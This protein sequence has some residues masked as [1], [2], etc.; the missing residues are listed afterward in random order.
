MPF[1]RSSWSLRISSMPY[2]K[3]RPTFA[4][5][6]TF[7]AHRFM[8][9]YRASNPIIS[10]SCTLVS[11][12]VSPGDSRQSR[13]AAA[14][15]EYCSS[16]RKMGRHGTRLLA[17]RFY[18]QP[19]LR[20]SLCGLAAVQSGAD[21]FAL[22]AFQLFTLPLEFT[23]NALFA[24]PLFAERKRTC[25]PNSLQPFISKRLIAF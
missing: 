1:S 20:K 3:N 24:L 4:F 21:R 12:K 25:R 7:F 15:G 19:L 11:C 9:A 5:R 22:M 8:E 17:R 13:G 14:S 23:L 6:R 10:S 2:I 16:V 18:A